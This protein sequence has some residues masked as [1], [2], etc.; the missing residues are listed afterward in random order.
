MIMGYVGPYPIGSTKGKTAWGI[1]GKE[2]N[3]KET[4]YC[5][6]GIGVLTGDKMS[7]FNDLPKYSKLFLKR[8]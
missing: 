2:Y 7:S 6:P 5:V 1:A 8:R 4:I 3:K